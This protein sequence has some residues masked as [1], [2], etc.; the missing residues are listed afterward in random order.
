MLRGDVPHAR[1]AEI[2]ERDRRGLQAAGASAVEIEDVVLARVAAGGGRCPPRRRERRQGRTQRRVRRPRGSGAERRQVRRPRAHGRTRSNVAASRPTTKTRRF[3]LTRPSRRAARPGAPCNSR[4]PIDHACAP[5]RASTRPAPRGRAPRH[6]RRRRAGSPRHG[7]SPVESSAGTSSPVS[8]PS[9]T[10]RVPP[11]SVATTGRAAARPRGGRWTCPRPA[12]AGRTRPWPR[13]PDARRSTRPGEAHAIEQAEVGGLALEDGP[14][15]TVAHDEQLR[16]RAPGASSARSPSARSSWSWPLRC[17]SRPTVPT[18]GRVVSRPSAAFASRVAAWTEACHVDAAR[19][20]RPLRADALTLG[21][22]PQ[23]IRVGDDRVHPPPDRAPRASRP[24]DRLP[25]G[26]ACRRARAARRP[27]VRRSP[28]P[29]PGATDT[30]ARCPRACSEAAA[31][32]AGSRS[33]REAMSAVL[34]RRA[35]A[36]P[37]RQRR[38]P[39]P[40][41]LRGAT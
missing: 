22:D 32:R 41:R 40:P 11:T 1:A 13:A 16:A 18:T 20:D 29:A 8:R 15:R 31:P 39:L 35:S 25:S 36:P 21:F 27:G 19:D 4:Q 12:T 30:R 14:Q 7:R 37:R 2:G 10:S 17:S 33:R 38:A 3:R 6:D 5:N 26:C 24:C 34:R 9:H 28:R 23:R